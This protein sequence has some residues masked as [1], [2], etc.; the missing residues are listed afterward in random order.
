MF[1]LT[2]KIAV[3]TGA[4]RGLGAAMACAL[5][6][7]GA[8][9]ILVGRKPAPLEKTAAAIR[10]DNGDA[11]VMTC[12]ITSANS[13]A[14]MVSSIYASHS[15]IDILINNAG[16]QSRA[17]LTDV[18]KTTWDAMIETHMTGPFMTCQ[19]VLPGMFAQGSGKIINTVS[20]LGELGRPFV[21]PYAA[22]KGGLRM[23]TRGLATEVAKRNVQVNAIGP[24]YFLT[25]INRDIIDDR[26]YFDRVVERVP[27]GRWGD[28]A[29]IGGAAVFLASRASDYISG[30][31]IYVD[32]GLTASF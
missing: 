27:A 2:G 15:R 23:L 8:E 17:P 13:I 19:A 28:P 1:N 18:A 30:Q 12:D 10:A 5:A 32:G 31:V 3:V 6:K 22:A 24:G 7:A 21:V 11:G 9:V 20:V 4:G 26:A 14:A 29:D 25:E 16:I